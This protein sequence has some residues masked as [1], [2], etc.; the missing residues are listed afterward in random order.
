[1][2]LRTHEDTL[3]WAESVE[4]GLFT[5]VM[6]I[7]G[8]SVFTTAHGFNLVHDILPEPIFWMVGLW[9]QCVRKFSK[10]QQ[11]QISG[12]QIIGNLL[13]FFSPFSSRESKNVIVFF[14]NK[15][16]HLVLFHMFFIIKNQFFPNEIGKWPFPATSHGRSR[17]FDQATYKCHKFRQL[18]TVLFP[19]L[20]RCLG[21]EKIAEKYLILAFAFMSRACRLP[22]SEYQCIPKDV[23]DDCSTIMSDSFDVAF[24]VESG[25]YNSHIVFSHLRHIREIQN[26]PFTEFCA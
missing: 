3:R 26:Q 10:P 12:F 4:E 7:T 5:S 22:D 25:T 11:T 23:L 2:P 20:I 1:M 19:L 18:S 21:P 8:K 14:K 17:L 13:Q 24:G 6:D 16:F 9:N 15:T